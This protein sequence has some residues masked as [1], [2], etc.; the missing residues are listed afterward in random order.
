MFLLKVSHDL[1]SFYLYSL[2]PSLP[3]FSGRIQNRKY[4]ILVPGLIAPAWSFKSGCHLRL[5]SNAF[6]ERFRSSL[7]KQLRERKRFSE[8]FHP[9]PFS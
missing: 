1:V 7:G 5:P 9:F 3:L 4:K 2:E 6:I 8:L